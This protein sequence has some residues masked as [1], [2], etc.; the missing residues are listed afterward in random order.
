[1]DAN[2]FI[3]IGTLIKIICVVEDISLPLFI[4]INYDLKKILILKHLIQISLLCK[5]IN[6]IIFFC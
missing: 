6:L 4:L 5:L 3:Y 1:M 2:I